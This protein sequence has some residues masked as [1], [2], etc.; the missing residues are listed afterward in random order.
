MKSMNRRYFTRY[1]LS[2]GESA[3]TTPT[4]FHAC[5][6]ENRFTIG[7]CDWSIGPARDSNSFK[8]AKQ[9]GL[10]IIRSPAVRV[11]YDVCS[12]SVIGYNI[13][14]EV[15]KLGK[16]RICEF[17]LKENGHLPGKRQV[18]MTKV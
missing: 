17:H 15:R 6:S 11:Y 1:S 7:A 8:V 16:D 10:D 2:V 14:Q 9:I 13:F 3:G 18:E 4:F 5:M 12:S